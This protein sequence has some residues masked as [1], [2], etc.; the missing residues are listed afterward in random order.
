MSKLIVKIIFGFVL[1]LVILAGG[2][3][4]LKA[5][6][7]FKREPKK[8]VKEKSVPRVDVAAMEAYNDGLSIDVDGIV[9]P[10]REVTITSEIAG[11]I[12]YKADNC[13][14]GNYVKAGTLLFEIDPVDFDLEVQR[15]DKEVRQA[16]IEVH[17]ID[18]QIE[19]TRSLM[20]LARQEIQLKQNEVQRLQGLVAENI[21]TD[22]ALDT[23][24]S[25]ELTSK[26]SMETLI[27]QA[28]TLVTQRASRRAAMD[29]AS[30]ALEKAQINL[31]RTKILAP[32]DGVIVTD[33]MEE[34]AFVQTG[35]ALASVEDTS[36]VEV[37]CDLKM[38]QLYM[39]WAQEGAPETQDG[40]DGLSYK[41]PN[42]PA[43][44]TYKVAGRE[45]VWQ[46]KLARYDGIGLSENRTV[47]CRVLVENPREA[48][49]M[50]TDSSA[51]N[52][53]P[54]A[55]MRNMFVTI[56]L[57]L[58]PM[59]PFVKIPVEALKPGNRIWRL[60]GNRLDIQNVRV[61][62]MMDDVVLLEPG[63]A[64]AVGDMVVTTP[65]PAPASGLEI[66][67]SDQPDPPDD[68]EGEMQEPDNGSDA[69]E[70]SGTMEGSDA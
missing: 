55:L 43:K 6:G 7:Q 12:K 34:D 17:S 35:T 13:R 58:D 24:K 32:I 39:L 44:V 16:E 20:G 53:V 54:P 47:P 30:T 5:A 8:E 61:A 1:P 67:R 36:A 26:N 62:K 56:S 70:G 25:G 65:L 27:N 41:L 9:V 60:D 59:A 11:R 50:S 68:D 14:P 22:T 37:Q 19:N 4:V 3:A 18:V 51:S 66:R 42:T 15:L 28:R 63:D 23:A 10:F 52:I 33:M 21:V 57:Q 64:Y 38:E 45:F 48:T 69:S 29:L 46:G 40:N 2:F 49:A 31:A